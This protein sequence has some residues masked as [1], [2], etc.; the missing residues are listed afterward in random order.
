M[1]VRAPRGKARA[2]RRKERLEAVPVMLPT[3]VRNIPLYEVLNAEGEELI[4]D[5]SMKILEEVGIEFR[6]DEAIEYWKDAGAEVNGYRV[7]IQREMLLDLVDKAPEE[8][9]LHGRIPQRT[10]EVGGK[11]IVFAPTYGSPFVLDFDNRRRYSTLDDLHKFHKLAHM[12]PSLHVSGGIT[13]EPI[14]V[15]VSKRHLRVAYSALTHSDKPFMGATTARER[16]E[17]TVAM[18]K[19]ALGEEYVDTHT[20]MVSVC[21]CNSPLVWDATMLDA[22]KGLRKTQSTG[23]ALAVCPRRREHPSQHCRLSDPDQRRGAGRYFVFA[24][25]SPRLPDDL[26]S[27]S[28]YRIHAIRCSHGRYPGDR[29]DELHDRS[30]GP[31]LQGAVALQRNAGRLQVDGR[32]GGV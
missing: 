2:S 18:A 30:D 27:L 4:H 9:T 14:D 6:D 21:N 28:R 32:T 17:D 25:G 26:R 13:C 12:L 19:I 1:A 5:A 3:L 16:A 10:V 22:V 20:V 29:L 24:A 31:T 8:F 23:A 7:R 11:N 15:A